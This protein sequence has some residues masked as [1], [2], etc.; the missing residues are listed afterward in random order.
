M[1]ALRR[2]AALAFLLLAALACMGMG[3]LGDSDILSKIPQPD[4]P[5][6]VTVIDVTDTS[7]SATD[8]SVEGKTLVPVELGKA[9]LSIDFAK[10]KDVAFL[11]DGDAIKATV[12]FKS[13]EVKQVTVSPGT[14]FYG[15][16][17]WGPM[18]LS[19][20]DIKELHF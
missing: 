6:N 18:R 10:I 19:G 2:L 13:G 1:P 3:G 11:R 16:T 8:F 7:F 14:T 4:R 5:F 15:R 20:K 12:T 9:E 17:P